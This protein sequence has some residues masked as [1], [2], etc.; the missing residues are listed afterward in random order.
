MQL[1]MIDLQCDSNLKEM[2]ASFGLEICKYDYPKLRELAANILCMF[3]TAYMCEQVFPVMSINKNRLHSR[4]MNKDL[5]DILKLDA[6]Q[7][8]SHIIDALVKD[9]RCQVSGSH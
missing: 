8:I 7:E 9:K 4:P 1:K 5:N 2:F 6:S 3:G